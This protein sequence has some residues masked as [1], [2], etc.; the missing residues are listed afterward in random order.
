MRAQ[1]KLATVS[2]AIRMPMLGSLRALDE[3]GGLSGPV[4]FRIVLT[5]FRTVAAPVNQMGVSSFECQGE[6]SVA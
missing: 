6:Q 2:K 4:A 3:P 5:Y 1:T